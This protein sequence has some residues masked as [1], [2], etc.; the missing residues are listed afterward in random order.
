MQ[1]YGQALVYYLSGALC[2]LYCA[3]KDG[4]N[5]VLII[6]GREGNFRSA[7]IDDWCMLGLL[8]EPEIVNLI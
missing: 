8:H 4:R 6:N 3:V 7:F 2:M 5:V 1:V